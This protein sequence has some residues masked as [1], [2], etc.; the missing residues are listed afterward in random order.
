MRHQGLEQRRHHHV[1]GS[2]LHQDPQPAN[3]GRRREDPTAPS[4]LTSTVA[5]WVITWYLL[6]LALPVTSGRQ[7]RSPDYRGEGGEE[8]SRRVRR[9]RW[10]RA[11][12]SSNPP[13]PARTPRTARGPS[14]RGA[15]RPGRAANAGRGRPVIGE[16]RRN[17]R[18]G[19]ANGSTPSCKQDEEA[20]SFASPAAPQPGTRCRRGCRNG[21]RFD[22]CAFSCSS[23]PE[24]RLST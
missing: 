13:T 19:G 3:G 1:N 4:S 14:G 10:P 8:Q 18:P 17:P 12:G 24:S 20:S 21:R 5:F 15:A 2:K 11:T 23:Y 7:E 22:Q 6:M 16:K 9:G